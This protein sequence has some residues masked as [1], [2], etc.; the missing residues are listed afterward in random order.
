MSLPRTAALLALLLLPPPAPPAGLLARCRYADRPAA[1]M[2]LPDRLRE[3]SGLAFT[4]DG[5][6]YAHDDERGVLYRLDPL[7]GD[8]LGQFS[9]SGTPREDF[10]ALAI[11][12]DRFFLLTSEGR[13]FA[14]G[15][16]ADGAAVP[17]TVLR[18]GLGRRCEFEALGA[19]PGAGVLLLACK[20][21]R[22]DAPRTG[23]VVYRWSV[24]RGA[25]AQPPLVPVVPGAPFFP[26]TDM[27]RDPVSGN[28]VLISARR[29][30]LIELSPAGAVV[31]SMRIQAGEH[32]QAEG[33]A[34]SASGD[35]YVSDEGAG[36]S[37]R[38]TRYACRG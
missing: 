24:E 17:F 9:L 2:K 19:D 30:E 29:H 28:Y 5:R 7:R 16:G 34:V 8:V 18:T 37:P 12:G 13:L 22:G 15:E 3:I 1:R 21:P 25:P 14:F 10:E 11:L 32:P 20:T 23:V 35:L 38:L 26:A 6:L 33:V 36:G 4:T 27:S 31:G